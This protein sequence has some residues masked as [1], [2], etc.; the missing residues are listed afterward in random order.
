MNCHHNFAQQEQHDGK[1]VWV[2][3]KGAIEAH[4]G[5]LGIIPGSMGTMSYI[6]RGKGNP[7]S[8]F[9]SSH[10]AGRVMSRSQAKRELTVE[11]LESRMAGKA[12]NSEKP[13]ALLDEHPDAYKDVDQVMAD[14]QDLTEAV[15]ALHQVLNYK[16][17]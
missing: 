1:M 6:V 14:Q 2:T 17:V 15:H 12:W 3:R 8:Y 16:G 5:K 11:S 13:E 4:D 9:S 10:G 7:D